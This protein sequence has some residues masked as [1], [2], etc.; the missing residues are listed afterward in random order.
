MRP[1]CVPNLSAG[2]YVAKKAKTEG[3][4]S[5]VIVPKALEIGPQLQKTF[6]TAYKKLVR[7]LKKAF[8]TKLFLIAQYL[9]HR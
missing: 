3:Y 9:S 6:A 8:K 4:Y 7:L 2:K 1:Y 5:A